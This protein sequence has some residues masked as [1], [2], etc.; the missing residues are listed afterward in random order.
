[1]T[2]SRLAPG[3]P[4]PDFTL[5]DDTGAE[6]SLSGLLAEEPDAGARARSSSTSTPP[7]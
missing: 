2:P 4:A 3:D 7:R 6:V 1:M 5:L